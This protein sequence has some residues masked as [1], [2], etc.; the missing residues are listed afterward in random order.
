MP[1]KTNARISGLSGS[2]LSA[3]PKTGTVVAQKLVDARV[4]GVVGHLNSGT[5]IPAS[6]IY[7]DAGI[8]QISPS[9][10]NPGYTQQGFKT[11]Y[12]VMANDIQQG[13]VLGDFVVKELGALSVAITR[14]EGLLANEDFTRKAPVHV[15]DRE[16]EKLA[17]N[18]E[19]RAK[20]EERLK[21]L[22]A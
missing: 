9:A 15:V 5:T 11:A 14:S 12:R 19:Q 16:R 17:A 6:K 8:P 10:T 21:S 4:N 13:K 7:A 2:R 22:E 18:R 3:D 1:S 20:L